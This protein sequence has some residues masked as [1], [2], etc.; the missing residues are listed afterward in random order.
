MHRD[1]ERIAERFWNLPTKGEEEAV[2]EEHFMDDII[3]KAHLDREI[4]VRLDGVKTVFDGGAG[5]GR[6]TI[7]LAKMGLEVTH[8]DISEPMINK[9]KELAA[10]EEVLDRIRFIQGRL[11]DLSRFSD[12]EFDLV[13]SFDAPVSYTYPRHREVLRELVRIARKAV[14][15][16]VS[17]RYGYVP[18]L[19]N[20]VQKMQFIV[21]ENVKDPAVRWYVEHSKQAEKEWQPDFGLADKLL[22]TGLPEDPDII[23]DRLEQ[24]GHPW[25]VNYCFTPDELKSALEEAGL[26]D[27]KLAG[28]GALARSVSRKML[29]KLLFTPEYR[30]RFLDLCYRFDSEPHVCGLG[31]DNL[32]ASGVKQR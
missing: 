12:G 23:F 32:V 29:K 18:Y 9:A 21:D 20:P 3:Q 25:P 22:D 6:F 28:P 4:A 15:V 17:S 16:S 10:S 1:Y 24:G 30:E 31:K 8:F 5:V 13:I 19:F 26:R 7:P 27:I 14:I 11:T 2:R